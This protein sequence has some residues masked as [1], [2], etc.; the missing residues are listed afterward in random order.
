MIIIG[1]I[2]AR[3]P[4]YDRARALVWQQ[5]HGRRK[6]PISHIVAALAAEVSHIACAE[7]DRHL[8]VRVAD[9]LGVEGLGPHPPAGVLLVLVG[10][11]D[12]SVGAP[13]GEEGGYRVQARV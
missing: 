11:R 6:H 4:H 8:G 12:R 13:G 3:W 1:V 2:I 7:L 5:H 10:S 9:K